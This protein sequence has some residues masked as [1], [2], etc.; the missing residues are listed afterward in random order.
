MK[1]FAIDIE[2][3]DNITV[4]SLLESY[5]NILYNKEKVDKADYYR[6][7]DLLLYYDEM[8]NAIEKVIKYYT[9]DGDELIKKALRLR[10]DDRASRLAKYRLASMK[11]LDF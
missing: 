5:D 2:C 3:A 10:R 9:V 1:D 8:L 4:A 7:E 11:N 6:H